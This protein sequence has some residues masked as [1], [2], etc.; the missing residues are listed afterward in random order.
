MTREQFGEK[1]TLTGSNV[2]GITSLDS[3]G[4]GVQQTVKSARSVLDGDAG[5]YFYS[6][7]GMVFNGTGW[8]RLRSITAMTWQNSSGNVGMKGALGNVP[9]YYNGSTF[10]VQQNNTQGT[11]LASAARTG[12]AVSPTQTNYNAKGVIVF[13]NCTAASGTGGLKLQFRGIDPISGAVSWLNATPTPITATGNYL[14]V[15]YPGASTIA[16]DVRQAT[17]LPLPR[18]WAIEIWTGDSTS[19]TYS[20]GYSYIL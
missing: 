11:L 17:S 20:I 8:D 9:Y 5:A 3:A 6:N 4:T 12:S 16:Q 7:G 19:Y 18:Q 10:D 14:Y 15:L 1:V 13:I 2:I